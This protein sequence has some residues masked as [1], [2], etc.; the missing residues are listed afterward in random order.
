M[1][2]LKPPLKE[3]ARPSGLAVFDGALSV[4]EMESDGPAIELHESGHA[5]QYWEPQGYVMGQ[6]APLLG[7]RVP[8]GG[9]SRLGGRGGWASGAHF[10]FR[11]RYCTGAGVPLSKWSPWVQATAAF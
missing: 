7:D 2:N 11:G 1:P 8:A 6:G 9:D 4:A 3:S 5:G 10:R